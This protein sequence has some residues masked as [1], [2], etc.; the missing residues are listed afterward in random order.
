MALKL[1]MSKAYD[2]VEWPF[3]KSMMSKMGFDERFIEFIICYVNSIQYSIL[4]NGKE[5]LSFKPSRGLRQGDPLSPYLFLFCEEGLSA[6][7][8]LAS[9]DKKIHGA[10]VSRS[11]PPITHLMFADECI[12]FGKVSNQGV[13]VLKEILGEYESCSGQ[14]VNYEKSMT[15]FSTNVKDQDKSRVF[16]AL[17]VRCSINPERYLGLPNVVG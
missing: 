4:I 3:I 6:L 12:L 9:Q 10:K 7:M 8:R 15:F 17:N 2:R 5:G 13:N 1:D 11:A 16:Q 14:C